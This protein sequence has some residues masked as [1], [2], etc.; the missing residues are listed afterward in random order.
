M[1]SLAQGIPQKLAEIR[2]GIRPM[3]RELA[4]QGL[5]ILQRAGYISSNLDRIRMRFRQL[6]FNKMR[7]L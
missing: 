2:V 3:G 1:I 4:Q 6:P 7:Q 5:E